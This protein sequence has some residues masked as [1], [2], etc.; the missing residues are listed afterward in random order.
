[1]QKGDIV[2]VS[3]PFSD[4]SGSKQR[5]ALVLLETQFDVVLSFI[6]TNLQSQD[7]F[8]IIVSPS[9]INKL[10]KA[11]LVKLSKIVTIDKSFVLGLLGSLEEET[12]RMINLNMI[13]LF[14]LS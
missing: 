6:T 10:K 13:K 1:M 8:D 2:L 12:I 9:P 11:S 14:Q 7:T 5:P 3:F 4:L